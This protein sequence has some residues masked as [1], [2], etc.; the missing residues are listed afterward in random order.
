MNFSYKFGGGFTSWWNA[1]QAYKDYSD[2]LDGDERNGE[3]HG[4]DRYW[5]ENWPLFG[6]L[7][8]LKQGGQRAQ[9]YYDNTGQDDYY[10]DR[11][12]QGAIGSMVSDLPTP[13]PGLKLPTMAKSLAK[14]YGAEV[15][16]NLVRE[17]RKNLMLKHQYDSD[18]ADK[19]LDYAV[20]RGKYNW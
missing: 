20:I 19:W 3:W 6:K 12:A 11:Y 8:K 13:L 2:R 1:Y 15:E 16:L 5:A 10:G 17:R 14:M 4:K 7:H 18:I 9:D